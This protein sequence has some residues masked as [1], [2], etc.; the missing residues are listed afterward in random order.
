M[1]DLVADLPIGKVSSVRRMKVVRLEESRKRDR[2]ARERV[3]VMDRMISMGRSGEVEKERR[4]S[5]RREGG[6]D[7]GGRRKRGV[8]SG[9]E[10]DEVEEEGEG[11]GEDPLFSD[12]LS[13]MIDPSEDG[14]DHRAFRDIA[15]SGMVPQ[16]RV[17]ASGNIDIDPLSMEVDRGGGMDMMGGGG[18]EGE[19]EIIVERESDRFVNSGT[20]SKKIRGNRWTE[21]E[22]A[23]FYHVGSIYYWAVF[24][25]DLLAF[26][27]PQYLS[28]YGTDFESMARLMPNRTRREIKNK[29]N[30]EDKKNPN[31]ITAAILDRRPIGSMGFTH[32]LTERLG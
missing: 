6:K 17:D 23:T 1:S 32:F 5:G 14:D 20:H 15:E 11:D 16:V 25:A 24:M 30:I 13:T 21:G 10:A 26:W 22:T 31:L 29:Y 3:K 19:Y 28:M 27:F 9:G 8:G 4:E 7:A 18:T 2:E 12:R